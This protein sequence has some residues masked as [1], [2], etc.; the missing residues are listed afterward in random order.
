[1]TRVLLSATVVAL[2]L[3]APGCRAQN[4]QASESLFQK[5]VECFHADKTVQ[6]AIMESIYGRG[7]LT[8]VFYSPQLDTC[9]HVAMS[10]STSKAGAPIQDVWVTDLLSGQYLEHKHID[11]SNPAQCVDF[12]KYL[13]DLFSRYGGRVTP[14][15]GSSQDVPEIKL[16]PPPKLKG[17][18][19]P[20]P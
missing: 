3:A 6:D 13:D 12:S 7:A 1:M 17:P 9:V 19:S 18:P 10:W 14:P 20:S 5:R 8:N 15:S 2:W 11:C 4:G 16:P